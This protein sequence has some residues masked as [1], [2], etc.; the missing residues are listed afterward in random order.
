MDYFPVHE[1]STELICDCSFPAFLYFEETKSCYPIYRKGP[2]PAGNYLVLPP[3]E[4]VATCE[5]NPCEKDG[6][7]PFNGSCAPLFVRGPHCLL[8]G[9]LNVN[10]TNFEIICTFQRIQNIVNAPSKPCPPGSRRNS[11]SICKK[12]IS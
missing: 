7:V 3:G 4:D 1:N 6:L 9:Y 5:K 2:C 11:L 10:P 12:T 8:N